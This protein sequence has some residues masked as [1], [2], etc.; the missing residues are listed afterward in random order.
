[1]KTSELK[2]LIKEEIKK[3]LHEWNPNNTLDVMGLTDKKDLQDISTIQSF[4]EYHHLPKQIVDICKYAAEE[5][6]VY[7]YKIT[8]QGMVFPSKGFDKV[9]LEFKNNGQIN[10]YKFI[11]RDLKS[12]SPFQY[13]IFKDMITK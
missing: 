10:L 8:Q 5:L 4:V 7:P 13:K 6:N 9:E 2:E 11:G 1:M 12:H 3:V